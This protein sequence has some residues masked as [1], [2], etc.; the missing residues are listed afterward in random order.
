MRIRSRIHLACVPMADRRRE[1]GHRQRA[2]APRHVVVQKSLAE[3]FGLTVT[4]AMWKG[5]PVVG[6]AVGGIVD[7]IVPGETGLLLE[8]PSIS[9]RFADQ[10]SQLIA[11][12]VEA[13]RL[14]RNGKRAR[15]R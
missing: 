12:P 10:L 7:Q 4:E 1:R 15:R 14:G 13:D 8:D 5:R 9:L 2:A 11:D 6:S 3:G